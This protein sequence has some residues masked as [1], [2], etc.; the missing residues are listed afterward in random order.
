MATKEPIKSKMGIPQIKIS[1]FWAST[2]D[3]DGASLFELVSAL[4]A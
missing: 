4:F 2:E 1:E 3:D